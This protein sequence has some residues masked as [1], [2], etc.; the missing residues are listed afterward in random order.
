MTGL[1][2]SPGWASAVEAGHRGVR[3][4]VSGGRVQ[5]LSDAQR[6][7][8]KTVGQRKLGDDLQDQYLRG[9]VAACLSSNPIDEADQALIAEAQAKQR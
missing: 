4:R 7:L 1:V 3:Q 6:K 2:D 5:R 9:A 8:L